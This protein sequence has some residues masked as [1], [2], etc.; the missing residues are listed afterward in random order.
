MPANSQGTRAI[1]G[2]ARSYRGNVQARSSPWV[3]LSEAI[4]K[5]PSYERR[6]STSCSTPATTSAGRVAPRS[7][8]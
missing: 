2:M 6:P 7:G 8:R 4:P 3:G 1:A 5:S